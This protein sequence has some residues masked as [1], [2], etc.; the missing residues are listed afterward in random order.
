MKLFKIIIFCLILSSLNI[1]PPILFFNCIR[2]SDVITKV[3]CVSL[4]R[5]QRFENIIYKGGLYP[6][7]WRCIRDNLHFTKEVAEFRN[8]RSHL[9]R[10]AVSKLL[11]FCTRLI[12]FCQEEA[13]VSIEVIW[14]SAPFSNYENKAFWEHRGPQCD[15]PKIFSKLN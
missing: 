10:R 6:K 1:Y 9:S 15:L 7:I 5:R 14:F 12:A 3:N 8:K 4:K 13:V 2:S 11:T